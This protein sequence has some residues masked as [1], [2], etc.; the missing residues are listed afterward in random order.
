VLVVGLIEKISASMK[1]GA[2]RSAEV[3]PCGRGPVMSGATAEF[4]PGD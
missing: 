2:L 4:F 1:L 3:G